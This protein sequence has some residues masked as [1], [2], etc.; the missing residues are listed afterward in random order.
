M[1]RAAAIFMLVFGLTLFPVISFGDVASRVEMR[2]L[3]DQVQEVKS[4]VLAIAA[5]LATLEER[6]LFP[7]GTQVS[8]F[9][10]LEAEAALR[11]DA[12]HLEIGGSP[13]A[14]HIYSFKELDALARGGVQRLY[15]GN[16]PTG[17]HSLGVSIVGKSANGEAFTKSERF[18][19]VKEV[20][21][22]L[23]G[24]TVTGKAGPAAIRLED[25]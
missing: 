7:S 14:H 24:V 19:F 6:L 2:S 25:W 15:V 10:A 12:I 13:A 4:D 21:P 11:L 16:L 20:K 1:S 23:L 8:V 17:T 5:E 3:D 9:V 18:S 22:S